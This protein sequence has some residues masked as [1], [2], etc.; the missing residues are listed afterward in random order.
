MDGIRPWLTLARTPGLHSGLLVPL[1]AR[2]GE[3]AAVLKAGRDELRAIGLPV[4]AAA[5]IGSADSSLL[6]DDERWLESPGH[7][8]VPWGS[9]LY[10]P[11]LREIPDAPVALF[12]VGDPAALSLPQVA[13]VGSR[14]PTHG[15]RASARNFAR[16]LSEG[17]LA[18]TSGLAMG[19]D[20]A[21]HR[22]A[23]SAGGTTLAVCGT[24]LDI[25][26]PASHAGLRE[27]IVQHGALVSEFPRGTPPL[28]QNFPRRNR[29]ISGLS[30]GTLVVEAALKSGSL[31][32]ARLAAAQGR[33]VFAIP[34][35][36]HNPLAKGCHQLIRDGATLVESAQD[37]FP[38]LAHLVGH[39]CAR[40]AA[41]DR[42]KNPDSTR[43]SPTRL[44]K[45]R[46]IL[47]D[48]LDFEPAGMDLLVQRTGLA[49]GEVASM[50]LILELDGRIESF[51]GGL[52]VRAHPE[53]TK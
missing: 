24:G 42:A 25:T 33:E 43:V 35:P 4:A 13:I 21:S 8:L 6:D 32:T 46:E 22:G 31:I 17:G 3:A 50:L 40:P 12:V 29:L 49:V 16:E 37:I 39:A 9:P 18:I 47:L 52:Y 11:L 15:G 38:H 20:A 26:Y 30:A 28:Q 34:G 48:A 19:I 14:N 51:P 1:L 53:G 44:D 27:E 41:P 45:D 2:F 5:R 23:L 10:P 7:H 36:I